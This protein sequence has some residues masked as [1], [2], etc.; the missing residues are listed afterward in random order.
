M[1]GKQHR[2]EFGRSVQRGFTLVEL[3]IALL[4]GIFIAGGLMILVQDNKRTF[5]SQNQLAQLQDEERLAMTMMTD[6]I[7]AAGYFP[8][9]TLNTATSVLPASGSM[10]AGQ[11]FTGLYSATAPG[12]TITVRYATNSGDGI[13]NCNGTSN[14]TGAVATYTNVFSVVTTGGIGQLV[15]TLNGTAYPLVNHVTNLSILY[16]INSTGTSNNV[17]TYKTAAQMATADWN[18][19]I[20]VQVK[21]TFDNPLYSTSSQGQGTQPQYVSLQRTV[22][23]MRQTGI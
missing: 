18:N 13:L 23:V 16:G 19:I 1:T 22:G 11:P 17:D 10:A 8:N 2:S 9:P 14:T 6:V 12:D 15:C 21:L 20:S 3:M 7:Q 4:V 5:T